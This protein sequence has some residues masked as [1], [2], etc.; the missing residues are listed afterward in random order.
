MTHEFEYDGQKYEATL[1]VEAGSPGVAPSMADPGEPA[2][3][4]TLELTKLRRFD[5]RDWWPV[6][7]ES[8][9]LWSEIEDFLNEDAEHILAEASADARAAD[10][11]ARYDAE[12]EG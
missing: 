9:A 11:E 10:G 6:G 2:E 5:G 3:G 1:T 4:P 12:K 8:R 7:A